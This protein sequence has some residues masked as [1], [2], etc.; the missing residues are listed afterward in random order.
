MRRF[1]RAAA[2]TGASL[3]LLSGGLLAAPPVLAHG[4]QD[5]APLSLATALTS[6]TL[7]LPAAL[8]LSLALVLYLAGVRRVDRAHPESPVPQRRIL[9]WLAGL[10]ATFVALSSFVDVYATSLFSVHMMQHLILVFVA[11][12]LLCLGAPVTLLLRAA[13][14]ELRR[15]WVLPVLRS[16]PLRI[17][18]SPVVDW[19]LFAVVMWASH[20][21]PL[22]DAALEDPLLHALEHALFLGVA[23]LFWWPVVGADPGPARMEYPV[24]VGYVLLEMPQNA[25][26]GLAIF[27]ADAVFYRHYATNAQ[28]WLP[29]P[30]ADQQLAGGV[31]WVAGDLLFLVPLL[32]VVVAWL[33][34]EER[35]GRLYDERT[36][37]ERV[38]RE[39]ARHNPGP[40]PDAAPQPDQPIGIVNSVSTATATKSSVR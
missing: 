12:P 36:T 19:T 23:F 40:A 35:K 29:D 4:A 21:S 38:A 13:S 16:R 31:M 28:A 7:E 15:R 1:V 5:L 39:R 18:T 32:L 25:F 9:A 2:A 11:A 10:L 30:L 14:P 26:L 20:F 22:F 3:F 8:A 34:D 6:W 33:A 17:V 37:R 27:S 24:R